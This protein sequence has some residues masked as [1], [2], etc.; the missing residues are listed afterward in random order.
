[1]NKLG[2]WITDTHLN[3]NNIDL[4]KQTRDQVIAKCKELNIKYIFH[5]GD[6]FDSRKG[7]PQEVLKVFWETLE[8]LRKAKLK[9]FG[10][11]G[12]HDKTNYS[13]VDSFLI[14]FQNHPSFKMVDEYE[15]F[16]EDG[17]TIHMV[18]YFE[19]EVYKKVLRK[20]KINDKYKNFLFTHIGVNGITMNSG[21]T[22]NDGI[23]VAAFNKFDLVLIGHYH[24][25]QEKGNI[26]YTGS[27]YPQTFG[28]DNEKGAW[29]IN[30]DGTIEFLELKYPK[31]KTLNVDAIDDDNIE[32]FTNYSSDGNKYRI[33]T[34]RISPIHKIRLE[35]VGVKVEIEREDIIISTKKEVVQIYD[36]QKIIEAYN[37]WATK[38][39]IKDKDFGLKLLEM[40]WKDN[41]GLK[42]FKFDEPLEQEQL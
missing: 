35:K 1:M 38:R 27:G 3:P 39:K 15:V 33:I 16:H 19:N 10:I 40:S 20:V 13:S 8:L 12:N 29:I 22:L 25:R 4:F 41:Q 28:E 9:M 11:V 21:H 30:D 36:D 5:G 32:D 26:V 2:I 24:N 6:I 42:S 37:E 14:P 18:A 17:I 34:S 7:Q 23:R 31:Y